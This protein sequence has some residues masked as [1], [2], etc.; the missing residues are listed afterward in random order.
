LACFVLDTI[1]PMPMPTKN[2]AIIISTVMPLCGDLELTPHSCLS[3]SSCHVWS[4]RISFWHRRVTTCGKRAPG[5]LRSLNGI[6]SKAGHSKIISGARRTVIATFF[7]T[8]QVPWPRKATF[9]RSTN[10][11]PRSAK[12][13]KCDPSHSLLAKPAPIVRG[14]EFDRRPTCKGP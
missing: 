4:F 13:K 12:T 8:H 2:T 5:V 9:I 1:S 10:L 14:E 6:C 3:K 7:A 11:R